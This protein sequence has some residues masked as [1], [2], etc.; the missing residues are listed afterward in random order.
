MMA[1]HQDMLLFTVGYL[2]NSWFRLGQ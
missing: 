1:I 2:Y